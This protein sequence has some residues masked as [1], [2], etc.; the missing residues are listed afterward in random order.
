MALLAA[1]ATLAAAVL[2]LILSGRSLF[3]GSEILVAFAILG[4]GVG[5]LL[6]VRLPASSAAQSGEERHRLYR[7]R[8][9]RPDLEV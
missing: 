2:P 3:S 4:V 5:R 7:H 6:R 8:H 9:R 1:F